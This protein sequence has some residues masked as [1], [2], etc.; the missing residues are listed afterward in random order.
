MPFHGLIHL[1]LLGAPQKMI[2]STPFN[3]Q[4]GMELENFIGTKNRYNRMKKVMKIVEGV[5][6]RD[7]Q[8][9]RE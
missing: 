7:C 1:W 3:F 8:W 4:Y 6:D 2:P 9:Y 5:E